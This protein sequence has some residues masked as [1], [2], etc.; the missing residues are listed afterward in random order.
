[1]GML[2]G[3]SG[4]FAVILE[5]QNVF[6]TTVFFE[7]ENAVA[8]GPEHIFNSLGRKIRQAGVMVRSFDDDFVSANAIHPVE[9][10]LGLAVEVSFDA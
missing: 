6:E 4:G 8:E 9:H 2:Q 3:R 10:A 1:M 7:V 5:Y